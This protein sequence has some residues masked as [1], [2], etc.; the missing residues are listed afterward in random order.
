MTW[1]PDVGYGPGEMRDENLGARVLEA[2]RLLTT[3]DEE[4][5]I[6]YLLRV[7]VEEVQRILRAANSQ[8]GSDA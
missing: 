8:P 3:G 6:A 4:R 1:G 2:R 5:A 7:D